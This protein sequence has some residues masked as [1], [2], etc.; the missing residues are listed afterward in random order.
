MRK[1]LLTL[2][3]TVVAFAPALALAAGAVVSRPGGRG[4]G[5]GRDVFGRDRPPHRPIV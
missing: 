3:V 2:L 4:A 1:A 5:R